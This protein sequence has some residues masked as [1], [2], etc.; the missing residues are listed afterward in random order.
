MILRNRSTCPDEEAVT[1]LRV[2]APAGSRRR[3]EARSFDVPSNGATIAVRT[4]RD[5]GEAVVLLHGG[6]GCPDYLQ[7]VAESLD[8]HLRGVTF[9]QRGVGGST[10]TGT[11]AIEDYLSDIEAVRRRLGVE[12]FHLFGHSWG[13]LLAQLYANKYPER[14]AS[15]VL[16]NAAAGVGAQWTQVEREVMAYNRKRS[17]LAGFA[18]LGLSAALTRLPGRVGDSAGRRLLARVWR[19]YFPDDASAPPADAKWLRGSSISAA[20]KTTAAIRAAE[21]SQL[22]GLGS[23]LAVPV[24]VVYG[25]HDIYGASKDVLRARFPAAQHVM[26]QDCGHLPWLQ[27]ADVFASLLS[28]FYSAATPAARRCPAS[29]SGASATTS[30]C[31]GSRPLRPDTPNLRSVN[32]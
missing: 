5:S 16:T 9:D 30:D 20:I 11:F 24:V 29:T 8:P 12:R 1:D 27:A 7:P 21:T 31:A 13:G 26:L 32:T 3:A 6:P 28:G 14:V 18:V 17:G 10:A 4:Q 23:R 19:N 22:E 25:E 15:M 2:A